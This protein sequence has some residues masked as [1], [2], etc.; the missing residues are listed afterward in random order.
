VPRPMIHP[1]LLSQS[2]VKR[3]QRKDKNSIITLDKNRIVEATKSK[4]ARHHSPIPCA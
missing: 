3:Y 1:S 4:S 2:T